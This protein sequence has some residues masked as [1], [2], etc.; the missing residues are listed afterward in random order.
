MDDI[1][2]TPATPEASTAP[3][4]LTTTKRK[5]EEKKEEEE[6]DK[7]TRAFPCRYEEDCI[8]S[9]DDNKQLNRHIARKHT[10]SS[11]VVCK[12]MD[13]EGNICGTK[14]GDKDDWL[15]HAKKTKHSSVEKLKADVVEDLKS[16]KK[17]LREVLPVISDK[18]NWG[19]SDDEE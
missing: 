1:T 18:G 2:T 6:K 13:K 15:K 17:F 9:Y 19:L 16:R 11:H 10:G 7:K 8:Y 4:A 12:A 14:F 3:T 5:D